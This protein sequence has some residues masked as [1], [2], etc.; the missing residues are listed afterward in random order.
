MS[1]RERQAM[2]EDWGD[3][4]APPPEPVLTG[5]IETD[6]DLIS[7]CSSIASDSPHRPIQ[8]MSGEE[9]MLWNFTRAGEL[10]STSISPSKPSPEYPPVKIVV[11]DEEGK[12]LEGV[13]VS[14]YQ[15]AK[16]KGGQV[17][18]I[19]ETSN[20]SGLAVNRNL[21]YGHYE[22]SATTSDGWYLT[23]NRSR[24]NVEFEKGVD[25]ILVAPTPGKTSKLVISSGITSSPDN[26]SGLR[27]GG[28]TDG[29]WTEYAPEP[30]GS[31]SDKEKEFSSFPTITNGIEYVGAEIGLEIWRGIS[32]PAPTMQQMNTRW[33]WSRPPN[34][35]VS[36]RYLIAN[37]QA[38]SF[39]QL[40]EEG[41]TTRDVSLTLLPVEGSEFFKL[42]GPKYRVGAALLKPRETTQLPLELDIPA[43]NVRVKIGRF[44][45][46]PSAAVME[47]L[48]WQ[49]QEQQP[50]L[51]LQAYIAP[52]S[53]W[54]ERLIN[55]DWINSPFRSGGSIGFTA[56]WRDQTLQPSERLEIPLGMKQDEK[57]SLKTKAAGEEGVLGVSLQSNQTPAEQLFQD[58]ME[59][60]TADDA[61]QAMEKL[62]ANPKMDWKST[63]SLHRNCRNSHD[64][65][66]RVRKTCSGSL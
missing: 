60:A 24:L 41:Y 30:E 22:L 11:H 9:Q 57:T 47:A 38:R 15:L 63:E 34:S 53:A 49:P 18:E 31:D 64:E 13:K 62:L 35:N 33:Y 17:L 7:I 54:V 28:L 21:P 55:M 4:D 48:N 5:I 51:W 36:I 6:G 65:Q 56:L 3:I 50:E 40:D 45:G 52:D 42:P 20:A 14:L 23:G 1:D 44:L 66:H 59:E 26:I 19:I 2:V 58:A 29:R 27:F 8:F 16:D 25:V 12:P 46:K 61:Y 32:Q 10:S 39:D 37:G 43:G